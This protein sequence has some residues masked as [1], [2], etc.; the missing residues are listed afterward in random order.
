MLFFPLLHIGD[1]LQYRD[2]G[3]GHKKVGWTTEDKAWIIRMNNIFDDLF[4][5]DFCQFDDT[6]T[7][8]RILVPGQFPVRMYDHD[9][10]EKNAGKVVLEGDTQGH[11]ED[12][13]NAKQSNNV[14]TVMVEE[15]V[16]GGEK[17]ETN[18]KQSDN[19]E[20]VQSKLSDL[21]N[22]TRAELAAMK[23][24]GVA[25]VSQNDVRIIQTPITAVDVGDP[26][27][28]LRYKRTTH[29][30]IIRAYFVYMRMS[31]RAHIRV[32]THIYTR[33]YARICLFVM[34]SHKFL[35]VKHC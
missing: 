10:W 31:I 8:H 22:L 25:F 24:P 17:D 12:E 6:E 19:A 13:S 2:C 3:W 32:Y 1:T 18:A 28:Q 7:K 4:G 11:K 29:T 15:D 35:Y 9:E 33:M 34:H 14:E 30:R 20:T 16:R 26:T 27:V 21:K 5:P 23:L